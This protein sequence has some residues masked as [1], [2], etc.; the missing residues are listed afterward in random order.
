MFAYALF[1]KAL[2]CLQAFN[3]GLHLHRLPT[4]ESLTSEDG[5]CRGKKE[6]EKKEQSRERG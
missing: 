5:G 3:F 4:Q 2:K 6:K 1:T